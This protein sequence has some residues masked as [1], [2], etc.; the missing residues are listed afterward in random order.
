LDD[1]NVAAIKTGMLANADVVRAVARTLKLTPP[2]RR[3]PP[4]MV[5]D[6]V[7]VSTSGHALLLDSTEHEA[8]KA[9]IEE[10]LPLATVLTPNKAEAEALISRKRELEGGDGPDI[11]ETSRISIDTID[12]ML[13][14]SSELCSL[15][16]RAVLLKGGHVEGFAARG[17]RMRIADVEDVD[18]V[19]DAENPQARARSLT[20]ER[21]GFVPHDANMEILFQAAAHDPAVRDVPVIVDVLCEEG[22]G[23]G[24]RRSS[25]FT[26]FVRPYLDSTSTHG[27]GCTLSAALACALA[28]GQPR[29][30]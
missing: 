17:R 14:A 10:L 11:R 9:L 23:R 24:E 22:G 1:I 25:K 4:I 26:L 15:G 19:T 18:I 29:T 7:C 2:S 13:D 20:I 30:H 16:P 12:D 6:P 28:R 8:L 27:T 21:G 5:L 3:R